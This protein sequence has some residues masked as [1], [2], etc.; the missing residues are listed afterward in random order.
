MYSFENLISRADSELL[1]GLLPSGAGQ[2]IRQID[3]NLIYPAKLSK[4]VVDLISPQGLLLNAKSRPKLI[5]LMPAS[6]AAELALIMGGSE[7][8]SPFEFL[9]ALKLS[10]KEDK[11]KFLLFFGHSY[12]EEVK[13]EKSTVDCTNSQ[14]PLFLHQIKALSKVRKILERDSERVL[15]HMPTGSGKTRTAVNYA[16]EYLR[17]ET[18]RVVVWLANSEELC[19]QAYSEFVRAWLCLGNREISTVR[20]WDSRDYDLSKLKDG[21]VVIGLAK[22]FSKLKSNDVGIRVLSSTNPLIIFDE[23]HQAV[24]STYKQITELL[25]RPMSSS[26]LLGLSAT[27][28]RSWDDIEKDEEL[29]RFFHTNKVTLEVAGYSN[30]VTYLIDEGYLAKPTFRQIYSGENVSLSEK[31]EEKISELLDLPKSV[32][33]KL[34]ENQKRNLLIVHEAEMLMKNHNRVILFASSVTQSDLLATVL[35]ARSI[36]ARSITSNTSDFDRLNAVE[37][38]KS[39]D[40]EKKILC[41]YGILTTG[42]DAPKTSAALIARPTTSLVLYSQMV[43]RALR[44]KRAGGNTHAEIVTVID[45]GIEQ[46]NSIEAAFSN[47]EDV[48]QQ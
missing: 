9:K 2:I 11:I 40:S 47:W 20:F 32:L 48:W 3:S 13:E 15:L 18:N 41:N 35:R 8:M 36:D 12:E 31:D 7:N 5:D 44:G 14:Y 23:A 39:D 4:L 22:A 25:L 46:F 29:S 6:E 30:P 28:G 24:A 1:D 43:G 27:P 37:S 34:G 38:Y 21:F 16:S 42:F 19:E 45:E 17:A 33:E 26:R 10:K